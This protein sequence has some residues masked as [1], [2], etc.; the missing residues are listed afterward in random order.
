MNARGNLY[1]S[2]TQKNQV[3]KITPAGKQSFL[4]QDHGRSGSCNVVS[5]PTAI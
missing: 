4:V 5:H 3:L 2:D 1:I